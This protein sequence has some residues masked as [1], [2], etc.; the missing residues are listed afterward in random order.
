M[1]QI[2]ENLLKA[3]TLLEAN[4]LV[5]IPTETVYG[6]AANALSE[7]AVVKIFEAKN[8]PSFNPL[9]VHV[10][11]VASIHKYAD[12]DPIS[13]QLAEAFMPG[14]FTLLLPKNSIIP[15]IVTAGSSKVA[16]RV[17]NQM[18][19]IKLLMLLKFPL[20]APSANPSGYV[21]PTTALHVQEGLKNKVAYILDGGQSE[22]GVESTIA[23]V[24]DGKIILH[25]TGAI[26]AEQMEQLTGLQVVNAES[27]ER[28]STAGQMKSHY[29]TKTP[30]YRGDITK[31]IKENQDKNLAVI[32]F[33]KQY[34]GLKRGHEYVLS[35]KGDLNEAAKH[36][37]AVMRIIDEGQF[38]MIITE[39][40]PDKGL[41]RA[42][43]D[44]LGRAQVMYKS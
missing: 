37:F 16:I 44:R 39:L 13:I 42:I 30:L 12:L 19:T 25:R 15:D 8:R 29:A 1:S 36:L 24:S 17:P 14:P 35:P 22:V 6:L 31:M 26:S 33:K 34:D 40:F 38:D 43:N 21:S 32:S 11:D 27:A 7:T 9:I 4:E 18:M 2:G 10:V 5:A 3:A 28:P 20:A 23:E 41:G